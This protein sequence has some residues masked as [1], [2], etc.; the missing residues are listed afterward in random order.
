METN[1]YVDVTR[2]DILFFIG[3][4]ILLF[5]LLTEGIMPIMLLF[6]GSA[7][8]VFFMSP[9]IQ[10]IERGYHLDPRTVL[11]SVVGGT[12]AILILMLIANWN[13]NTILKNVLVGVAVVFVISPAVSKLKNWGKE[14]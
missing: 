7:F 13:T 6:A 2:S 11:V 10:L 14:F 4:G 3:V 5:F 9:L 12:I 1:G 8:G